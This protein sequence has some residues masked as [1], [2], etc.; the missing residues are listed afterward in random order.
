MSENCV[1]CGADLNPL[2]G[3]LAASMAKVEMLRRW[4]VDV[5][6]PICASC[7]NKLLTAAERRFGPEFFFE[8]DPPEDF[9]KHVAERA[10]KIEVW[11]Y[12][13]YVKGSVINLGLVSGHVILGTGP[14]AS[15]AASITDFFGNKS[16]DYSEKLALA[17]RDCLSAV[18]RE[19]SRKGA[20]AVVGL[21]VNY[22]EL[23]A[24]SGMIMVDMLGT[25]VAP[26][27]IAVL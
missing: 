22:T 5:P 21:L 19:A 3:A 27:R 6:A 13:P 1:Q 23:T 16:E 8:D 20:S 24:A 4:D 12:D 2:T 15:I 14:L 10:A 11:T 25:A 17:E 9:Q 26:A 7:F 18:K